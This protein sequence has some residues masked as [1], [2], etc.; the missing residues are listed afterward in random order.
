[1]TQHCTCSVLEHSRK[2]PKTTTTNHL[3]FTLRHMVWVN[4]F[5]YKRT[6]NSRSLLS[7]FHFFDTIHLKNFSQ[8]NP[9][10]NFILFLIMEKTTVRVKSQF[11]SKQ[12]VTLKYTI[13]SFFLLMTYLSWWLFLLHKMLLLWIHVYLGMWHELSC[14]L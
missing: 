3:C 7:I 9:C 4:S 8:E 6:F 13:L 1:M 2:N 12:K 11:L 14:L 10:P 5:F